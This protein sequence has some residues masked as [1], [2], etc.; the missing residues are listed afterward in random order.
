MLSFATLKHLTGELD[1]ALSRAGIESDIK[2]E[3]ICGSFIFQVAYF[4][5]NQ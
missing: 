2:R 5:D 3:S 4:I 1:A